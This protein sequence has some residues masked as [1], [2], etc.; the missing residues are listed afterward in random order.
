MPV[1]PWSG[2]GK[3]LG[4][5]PWLPSQCAYAIAMRI[6]IIL[7]AGLAFIIAPSQDA[8]AQGL[9]AIQQ[10]NSLPGTTGWNY[11]NYH[12]QQDLIS[13]FGSQISVN[14]GQS[15]DFYVTTTAA[16]F[17]IDIYRT[18]YYQGIGAR[19]VQ[20][21]GKFPGV[22]QAIPTPDPVTGMIACT[23]WTKATTLQ[24]PSTWVTGVYVAELTIPSG[25]ASFILFVVRNDGGTED[26]VFQ[27]SVTTYKAYDTWG[28]TSLYQNLTNKSVY[29]YVHATKVSFDSPFIPDNGGAGAYFNWEY[30]FV[31]WL[32]EQ[33][34]N[35]TYT[36]NVD[37]DLS[38]TLLTSHK[39]FLSVGHD[40]YWSHNMRTNVQ[41]A[42]NT[43]VNVG[44]FG[45]DA[46]D[47]QIR[48][49]PNPS[50]VPDRVVVGYKEFAET[51]NAPGPDPQWGVNNAVLTTNWWDPIINQPENAMIGVMFRSAASG[52]YV[53]QNAQ[54]WVYANSGFVNGSSING[55]V[56][57]EFDNVWNNGFTPPGLTVLSSSPVS[58]GSGNKYNANSTIYTAPSGAIVFAAGTTSWS[59]GLSSVNWNTLTNAGIQKTTANILNAFINSA[60]PIAGLSPTS[61]TYGNQV[62]ST[63]STAQTI[64][65]TSSGTAPLSINSIGLTGTN[66]GDFAQTN[67]CPTTLA[68]NASC[69]ISVTFTPSAVGSRSA[70]VTL[71][72]NANNS[73][74]NVGLS[75]TGY[76]PAPIVSLSP[77]GLSFGNQNVGTTSAAQTVTLTNTGTAPLSISS[78]GLTGTNAGDFAETNTCPSGGNTLAVNASCSISVTFTPSAAT[79]RSASV[80]VTDN[81]SNS[82]QSVSLSGTGV[83][84]TI[85]FQD[86]FE[87]GN[88]SQWNLP[89]SDSSGQRTV[90]TAVVHSG[91]YAAAFTI[92]GS[93]YDY[94]WTALAGG[95]QSQTFTRFYFQ[96][97]NTSNGTILAIAHNANNSNVWEV[98]YD[99]STKALDFYF[100][101]S[102]GTIYSISS[103]N[104]TISANTWYSVEI[105]DTQTTTGQAQA[106]I[107]GT[108]VG[109]FNA[110][111]SNA[112]PFAS[113]MLY[114]GAPGTF[115]FDDVVVASNFQ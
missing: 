82:P 108:S 50:G 15:I 76:V 105:Q 65:V 99:G 78:I 87:S 73:P 20:S 39:G 21:L 86:G 66:R 17:T 111:L 32:E 9:N 64:T 81:A 37:V 100:W 72:D 104:Q 84:G 13:G 28:G 112:N 110:N 57:Y 14:H 53:V 23:S 58:D 85:Y 52:N 29:P 8:A 27:T 6:V 11:F 3:S 61:L 60:T 92:T 22:H 16:S 4:T 98:D 33:G 7:L 107:N 40:E 56:G 54:S 18:G 48:F 109:S 59:M 51:K 26:L 12:T 95:P 34:Y 113:L 31:Y 19:L 49:E 63:T 74:Q 93:Q 88:F 24:I 36:T 46:L 96:L 55:L 2:R 94:I 102:S 80:T 35:V 25:D 43:G 69:N 42:I 114:N 71:T 83:T 67:N 1:L 103:A 90:Q 70:S 91:T 75:G 41:N 44:F 10:E 68:I 30:F 89:S 45:A 101:S 106:W 62:V 47:W 5:R 115:Y 38:N 97:T 79:S 77:A